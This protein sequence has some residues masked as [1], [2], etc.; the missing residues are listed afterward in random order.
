MAKTPRKSRRQA[1]PRR[2]RTTKSIKAHP[3]AAP[4]KPTPPRR[5]KPLYNA[6][7]LAFVQA[8]PGFYLGSF[9][10]LRSPLPK[11]F[12]LTRLIRRSM[13]QLSSGKWVST[14]IKQAKATAVLVAFADKSDFDKAKAHHSGKPWTSPFPTASDAFSAFVG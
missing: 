6:T 11:G 4:P 5:R 14:T 12:T 8:N 7:F 1:S 9:A 10:S 13:K 3:R 2:R